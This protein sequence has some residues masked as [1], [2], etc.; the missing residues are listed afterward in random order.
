MNKQEIQSLIQNTPEG[1]TADAWRKFNIC[2]FYGTIRPVL[3]VAKSLF[4]FRKKS[5]I[6]IAIIGLMVVLDA[7]CDIEKP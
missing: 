6:Y 4:S 2:K 7:S 1:W 3:N 5:A